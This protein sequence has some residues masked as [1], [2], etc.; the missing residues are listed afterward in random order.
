MKNIL[1]KAAGTFAFLLIAGFSAQ[2]NAQ[3]SNMIE[4]VKLNNQDG[5]GQLRQLIADNFDYTNPN[6]SE[7]V[8]KS[9]I[10][11]DVNKEGK[12]SNVHAEGRCKYVSKELETVLKDLTY[13]FDKDKAMPFTYVM[14]VEVAIASR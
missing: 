11:F 1:K 10:K 2:A 7:G 13:K 14:P 12:I 8:N 5:F 3:N 9:V 6:L 4:E